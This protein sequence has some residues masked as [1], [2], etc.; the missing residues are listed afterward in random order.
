MEFNA[1]DKCNEFLIGF[2][3]VLKHSDVIDY[4]TMNHLMNLL[5]FC[6]LNFVSRMCV[7]GPQG[8]CVPFLLW[9]ADLENNGHSMY[10]IVDYD[11]F[12]SQRQTCS[13]VSIISC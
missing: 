12:S 9:G 3:Y 10:L 8:M 2:E 11:F 1:F 4:Q 5:F 6:I 13:F 7:K